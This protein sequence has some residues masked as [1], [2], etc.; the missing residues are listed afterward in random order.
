MRSIASLTGAVVVVLCA[1]SALGWG[2]PF[3]PPTGNR[4]AAGRG[5]FPRWH[6]IAL[7]TAAPLRWVTA[8]FPGRLAAVDR[9]GTLWIFDVKAPGPG[10]PGALAIAGRYG[11]VAGPD[12]APVAVPLDRER[13][14]VAV[15]GRD[16][17]LAIWSDGALRGYD[18]GAPLSRLTFPTPV[19]LAGREWADLLAVAADGAVVLIGNLPAGP[20]VLARV[21][22][23]ALPDARITLADLDGDGAP[24]AVVLAEPTDR[25]P[26]RV[27]GDGVEAGAIA[28]IAVSPHALSLKARH[29]PPA[30]AVFE[31]LVPVLASVRGARLGVVVAR[32]TPVAGAA[33]SLLGWRDGGLGPMAESAGE[34]QRWTHVVGVADLTGGSAA[35]VVAVRGPHASGFLTAYR[36]RGAS[37]VPVA[38]APGYSSHAAG[39][40][41]VDQ[42]LIADLDGNGRLEVVLPHQSRDVLAALEIDGPR[43]VER[44]SVV[45]RSAIESNLV[46]ADLDGDGLLDLAVADRGGLYVFLSA[47]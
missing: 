14:G 21:A 8:A 20:R 16:G 4:V 36:Q 37:L 19:T 26:H 25:Y 1:T 34:P 28:V 41:N 35:E 6:A 40:R 42:A 12:S 29:V 15:V 47:R 32:S 39:S 30:P 27:L 43:F 18:V 7:A 24:E 31:D 11:D 38:Q 2:L 23:R 3:G 13:S 45:F 22:A 5:T 9:D 44:W 33:V 46:A 10:A 17:R